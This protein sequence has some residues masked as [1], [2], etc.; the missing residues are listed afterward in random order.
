MESTTLID[1]IAT[2]NKSNI[3]TSGV[4]EISISDHYMVYC[5]RKFHGASKRQH[6]SFTTRQFKHFDQTEFMND[7][8]LVDWKGIVSNGDDIN[9][10]IEQWIRMFSL[11]LERHVPV[12]NRRVSEKFSPWLTKDLKLL[13][14]TRDR[15]KKKPCASNPKS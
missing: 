5:V 1:H 3:V 13:S 8:S 11:I 2:T 12:R 15:L 7:L 10:I 4:H 9:L 14:A 6:K